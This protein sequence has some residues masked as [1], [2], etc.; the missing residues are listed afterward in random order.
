MMTI[1]LNPLLILIVLFIGLLG[2]EGYVERGDEDDITSP[3]LPEA[4]W[5]DGSWIVLNP[6]RVGT[7]R[8]VRLVYFLP[9]NLEYRPQVVPWFRSTVG[10]V[11]DFYAQE[12]DVHGYGKSSFQ[13]E[14]EAD[15]QFKV[16]RVL[17]AHTDQHYQYC[18]FQKVEE[19]LSQAFDFDANIYLVVIDNE[20]R[21]IRN[22]AGSEVGGTG[23]S[24]GK[25]GGIG[26]VPE[27][28]EW[29][30]VAHELGH[31]FGLRHN[32][33]ADASIM[34]YSET[35][36]KL[37]LCYA[38]ILSVHPYFNRSAPT[39]LAPPAI[40]LL[41]VRYENTTQVS[42]QVLTSSPAG[43]QQA[44]LYVMTMEPHDA[45]GQYELKTCVGWEGS[46]QEGGVP[47]DFD[48]VI[49]SN[50]NI[51]FLDA[52]Q[53]PVIISILDVEGNLREGEVAIPPPPVEQPIR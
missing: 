4:P 13:V 2:C 31:A 42:I 25:I 45:A 5:L 18:T 52:I 43:L 28:V 48:G 46:P 16:H 36:S 21:W 15:D 47:F 1:K 38:S 19:E 40:A 3:A 44:M 33:I 23:L 22:C 30:L 32:F 29:D 10:K 20:N 14:R 34:S 37:S 9:N 12:M 8:T 49:P 41:P 7:P 6:E 11:Q 26:L 50:P 51:G 17:G 35:R 39:V 53:N 27:G 24:R